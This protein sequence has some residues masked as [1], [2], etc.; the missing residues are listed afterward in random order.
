ML[1]PHHKFSDLVDCQLFRLRKLQNLTIVNDGNGVSQAHDFVQF[2]GNQKNRFSL[3]TLL[4][5]LLMDIFNSSDIQATGR[6]NKNR[7]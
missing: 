7:Q 2:Q 6:L 4:N 1:H 5:N 3:G